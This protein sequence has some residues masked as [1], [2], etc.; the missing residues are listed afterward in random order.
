[1]ANPHFD[2]N[3][4][5]TGV[6]KPGRKR[7]ENLQRILDAAEEEFVQR[8]YRGA[9]IQA[10][11]DRAGLPK[12]NIHYYFKSKANLYTSVLNNL[13]DL[14]NTQFSQIQPDDDPAVA[15]DRFIREK[16]RISYTQPRASKLFAMEVIAGAPYLGSYLQTDIRQWVNDRAKVIQSWVDQG[17]MK[18]S[19]PVQLIFLI[20]SSTQHYADF[21]TQ[22][23][24]IM[25]QLTYDEATI[26]HISSFLSQTIL[27]GCG[28]TPPVT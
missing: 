11:A 19:D 2:P 20:W 7:D 13:L 12:A 9:T 26:E 4:T 27:T 24:T 21:E 5:P 15:L 16:V 23:L 22:V 8:G 6:Y 25:D 3:T 1:M 28:L 14:W 18:T 17:L 10:I